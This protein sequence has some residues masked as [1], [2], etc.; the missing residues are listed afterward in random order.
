[1]TFVDAYKTLLRLDGDDLLE[2]FRVFENVLP[3]LDMDAY[4]KAK[5]S[6]LG[7]R[8][9]DAGGWSDDKKNAA[10]QQISAVYTRARSQGLILMLDGSQL[11]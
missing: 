1:M 3:M 6:R 7:H 9:H 2:A 10:R 4:D 5:F 11:P 8:L